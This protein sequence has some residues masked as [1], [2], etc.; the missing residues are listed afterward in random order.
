MVWQF[1]RKFLTQVR[2]LCIVIIWKKLKYDKLIVID[3]L[4]YVINAIN[5]FWISKEV[6]SEKIISIWSRLTTYSILK[7]L[8]DE[9]ATRIFHLWP[10]NK[11]THLLF[12]RR[13]SPK[14]IKVVAGT[15][16]LAEGGSEHLVEK[17]IIHENYAASD[18]WKN[19]ISLIKV[20]SQA[21]IFLS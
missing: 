15:I 17:I 19:D 9:T 5:I 14:E 10:S 12:F 1:T 2:I 21:L 18:S 11:K 20:C 4:T 6:I 7:L 3:F 8:F 16:N 13:K